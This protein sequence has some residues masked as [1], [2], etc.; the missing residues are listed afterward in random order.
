MCYREVDGSELSMSLKDWHKEAKQ[1]Y[2]WNEITQIYG[3]CSITKPEDRLIAVAGFAKSIQ[4]VVEDDY[5]AGLWKKTI[6]YNLT[7]CL[8]GVVGELQVAEQYRC[9]KTV[10]YHK[11]VKPH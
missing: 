8:F 9:R 10:L 6:P 11:I 4:P 3:R 1:E 7:W 5:L 2:F